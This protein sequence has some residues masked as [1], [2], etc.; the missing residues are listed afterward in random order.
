MNPHLFTKYLDD[1]AR[2]TTTLIKMAPADRLNWVPGPQNFMTLGQLLHHLAGCP[3]LFTL[4]VRDA[5]PAPE[6]MPRIIQEDLKNTAKPDQ[7][8]RV[9]QENLGRRRKRWGQSASRTGGAGWSGCRG[10][11][12]CRSTASCWI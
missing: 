12:R 8:L 5:M 9:L 1:I 6:E 10:G 7:A 2:P 4:A 3:A 11:S